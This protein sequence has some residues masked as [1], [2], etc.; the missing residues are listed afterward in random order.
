M[1]DQ[2]DPI[3]VVTAFGQAWADHDLEKALAM[4]A[5][6]CI[7]DDTDPAPDGT[8]HRGIPAIRASWRPI[9]ENQ[10]A[11]FE[12][13]ETFTSGERVVQRWVYNWGDGHVRGVDLFQVRDGKVT[14]KRSYVK[15]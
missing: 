6:D 13:E 7:F 15:G 4:C 10:N 8:L 9:F 3:D 11:H 5:T 1:A 12:V 2:I 14:E